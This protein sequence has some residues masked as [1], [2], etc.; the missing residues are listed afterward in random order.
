MF[1]KVIIQIPQLYISLFQRLYFLSFEG[2]ETV[3]RTPGQQRNFLLGNLH[4]WRALLID[5][6]TQGRWNKGM[7]RKAETQRLSA[8]HLFQ[9][10]SCGP[11]PGPVKL[12]LAREANCSPGAVSTCQLTV[13]RVPLRRADIFWHRPLEH[14]FNLMAEQ[15]LR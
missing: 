4:C 10:P 5:I 11:S 3:S 12:H 8:E 13:G 7:M 15:D 2:L 14:F 1:S 9:Q 6:F